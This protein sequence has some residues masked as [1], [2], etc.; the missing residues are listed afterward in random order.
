MNK[1]QWALASLA[2]AAVLWV[3]EMIIHWFILSRIYQETATVWRPMEAMQSMMPLMWLGYILFA[4]FFVYIYAK[5]YEPKEQPLD[6]GLRFGLVFG[7]GLSAMNSLGWY[8]VLPI[9]GALAFQWF[10]AGVTIYAAAGIAAAYVYR[11]STRSARGG[12]KKNA[13]ARR[14]R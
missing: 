3:L 4:P 2:V 11:P 5:G 1:K 10:L 7:I 8:A 13:K 9:P 12:S 14:R 6:Q